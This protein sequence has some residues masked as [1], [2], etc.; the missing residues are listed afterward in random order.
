MA[1]SLQI[2]KLDSATKLDLAKE[3]TEKIRTEYAFKNKEVELLTTQEN[4][5]REEATRKYQKEL[6][7]EANLSL[8]VSVNRRKI[9]IEKI[10]NFPLVTSELEALEVLDELERIIIGGSVSSSV[11]TK[12][13]IVTG[14]IDRNNVFNILLLRLD[15]TISKIEIRR[16]YTLLNYYKNEQEK[17]SDYQQHLGS[18]LT[19]IE[20]DLAQLLL[21]SEKENTIESE[22][23]MKSYDSLAKIHSPAKYFLTARRRARYYSERSRNSNY[24]DLGNP[25]NFDSYRF[26]LI[27]EISDDENTE[28]FS[29]FAIASLINRGII[30]GLP[31]PGYKL[32]NDTDLYQ[33]KLLKD[34]EWL[35]QNSDNGSKILTAS[36]TYFQ[37]KKDQINANWFK[38]TLSPFILSDRQFKSERLSDTY[39]YYH[40]ISKKPIGSKFLECL[41]S[42]E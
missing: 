40:V 30:Q 23:K 25:S 28:M 18:Y 11:A 35:I 9:L 7:E 3:E 39:E 4:Q 13:P 38:I 14:L 12:E 26:D 34:R 10:R 1:L 31:Y 37:L 6:R 42:I 19:S 36:S 15:K 20:K 21:E 2:Q 41:K 22:K 5:R 32:R 24:L 27:R 16:I 29:L 17:I 33:N 8:Q